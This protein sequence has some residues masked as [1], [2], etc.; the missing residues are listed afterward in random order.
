[1]GPSDQ[2][3]RRL[4]R[5][6]AGSILIN[7]IFSIAVCCGALAVVSMAHGQAPLPAS[8]SAKDYFRRGTEFYDLGRCL[9]AAPGYEQA[10]K[11]SAKPV[12]L[13]NIAQG[14]RLAGR[15]NDDLGAYRGSVRRAPDSPT[16]ADAEARIAELELQERDA[17]SS[18]P[19]ETPPVV[20]LLVVTP[21]PSNAALTTSPSAT[22]VASAEPERRP[23]KKRAWVWA[24]LAGSLVVVS[25]AV[26][27]GVGLGLK[28]HAL[29]F[30]EKVTY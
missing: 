4:D 26:G 2:S 15:K 25:L 27:L 28:S 21:P 12:L 23:A 5:R 7:R 19:A 18:K 24:V 20:A 9:D 10:F 11:L 17:A 3:N 8:D 13:Y 1:M 14:Y 29:G 6:C 22:L 16:R 30:D